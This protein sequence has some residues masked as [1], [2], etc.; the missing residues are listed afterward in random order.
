MAG[1]LADGGSEAG[2]VAPARAGAEPPGAGSSTA[3]ARGGPVWRTG[4]RRVTDWASEID[5]TPEQVFPLLCPVREYE[6]LDGWT[7]EMVYSES[8]VAED[9]CVFRTIRGRE[10]ATWTVSR[11]EPPARIEFVRVTPD[12]EVCSLRISLERVP[13]GTR[14]RWVRVFTGLS[15]KGDQAIDAWSTSVDQ[16]L[17]EKIEYFVQHGTMKP[18]R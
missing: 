8:G 17:S 3:A 15:D 18:A 16:A 10:V 7:A 12:V 11:Y 13:Q 2:R 9:H 1:L 14:L 6:W 5:A 4:R